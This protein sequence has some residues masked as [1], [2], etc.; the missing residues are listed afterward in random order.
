[1]IIIVIYDA[2]MYVFLHKY[3]K[4]V[5]LDWLISEFILYTGPAQAV[6]LVRFW[7]EQYFAEKWACPTRGRTY[8]RWLTI[9]TMAVSTL[10]LGSVS[11]L[12]DIPDSP[13]QPG[14]GFKF[15]KRSFGKA[16]VVFRSFQST[17]FRQCRA[18]ASGQAGQALALFQRVNEIHNSLLNS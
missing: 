1:M 14:P 9:V 6:R 2:C 5:Y 18:G 12:P 13:H 11:N 8:P 15:P 17:W 16:T 4:N 3:L 7:P 10:R